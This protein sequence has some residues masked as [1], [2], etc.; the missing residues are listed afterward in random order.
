MCTPSNPYSPPAVAPV[1]LPGVLHSGPISFHGAMTEDEGHQADQLMRG[2]KLAAKTDRKMLLQGTLLA[3]AIFVWLGYEAVVYDELDLLFPSAVQILA[4]AAVFVGVWWY[5]KRRDQQHADLKVAE[6]GVF[7]RMSGRLHTE[8]IEFLANDFPVKYEWEDFVGCRIADDV[9]LLYVDFPREMNFLAA[10]YFAISDQW[11]T[12]KALIE[13]NVPKIGPSSL[14]AP[15]AKTKR[16]THIAA[17]I[18]YLNQQAWQKAVA[19]FDAVLA[20]DATNTQALRGRIV[21]FINLQDMDSALT[22]A[23]SAAEHG[24]NDPL[25]RRMRASVM[26]AKE[27]FA[28]SLSDLNWLIERNPNDS[29]S[30]R[31]RGLVNLKLGN[32]EDSLVDLSRSIVPIS[33]ADYGYPALRKFTPIESN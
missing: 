15:R 7:S 17:G 12:A 6:K 10:S 30:L 29:D 24:V 8:G 14:R 3:L 4:V 5:Q 18:G 21:A 2:K 20:I 1:V 11:Q 19:E 33:V 31:D 25:T 28:E 9:V 27:R 23:E 22:A 16:M 26:I 13:Q 32:A